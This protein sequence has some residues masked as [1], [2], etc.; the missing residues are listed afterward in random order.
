MQVAVWA[1]DRLALVHLEARASGF[2]LRDTSRQSFLSV[3]LCWTPETREAILEWRSDKP[4][5]L[6]GS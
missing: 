6:F 3:S 1:Q 2:F 4:F 5:P